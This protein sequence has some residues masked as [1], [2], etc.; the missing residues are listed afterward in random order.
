MLSTEGIASCGW[1]NFVLNVVGTKA[2]PSPFCMDI[3]VSLRRFDKNEL[4]SSKKNQPRPDQ[5]LIKS[6]F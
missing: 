5:I 2:A 3:V 6:L 4:E 1:V